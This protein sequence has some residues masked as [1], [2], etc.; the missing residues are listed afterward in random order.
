MIVAVPAVAQ[1]SSSTP[2][3]KTLLSD[4]K[5]SMLSVKGVHI[6]VTSTAGKTKSS[7]VVDI[8]NKNGQE[9]ITS[10]SQHVKIIVTSKNAYLSGNSGGLTTIMGLS[11]AQAGK[12]GSSVMVM[13]AG[14]A[15]YTSLDQNLTIP[16]LPAMLPA[17][18]NKKL[19]VTTGSNAHQYNLDWSTAASSTALATTTVLT[20]TVGNKTLPV[21]ESI[22]SS[23][24]LGTTTFTKWNESVNVSVPATSSLVSYA[25]VF[26]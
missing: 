1:A 11:K 17:S 9:T 23:K 2:S 18:T 26:G 24:G 16:I 14:S 6:D 15:E 4:A 3:V 10:G 13:K 7:V 20:F 5:S 21:T 25:H 19:K 8:G 12:L 22:K